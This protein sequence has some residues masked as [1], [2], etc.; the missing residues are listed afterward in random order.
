MCN[1]G[2]MPIKLFH[3]IL[4]S[5][6]KIASNSAVLAIEKIGNRVHEFNSLKNKQIDC[7]Q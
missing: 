5:S 1:A 7:C 2:L 6:F 3:K 4:L